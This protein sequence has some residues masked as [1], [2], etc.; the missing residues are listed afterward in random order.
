MSISCLICADSARKMQQ[1]RGAIAKYCTPELVLREL[2]LADGE[3]AVPEYQP[4]IIVMDTDTAFEAMLRQIGMLRRRNPEAY[5]VVFV[6]YRVFSFAHEAM[7]LERVEF[8]P[9]PMRAEAL[10]ESITRIVEQIRRKKAS[11]MSSG[12]LESVVNDN[13]P[14]IRQ[15]YLSLLMRSG[16]SDAETVKRKFATLQIDC[17]GPFYTVVIV[18]M[19]AERGKPDYEAV[20]FLVLSSLRSMLKTEGYQVYIFFDSE[21]RINCLIGHEKRLQKLSIREIMERLSNYCLLYMEARLYFGIGETVESAAQIHVSFARAESQMR[22]RSRDG[23]A[24]GSR[25]VEAAVRFMEENLSD[26]TLDLRTVSASL[27][28]SRSYFS[29][30]FRQAQGEGFSAY[31]QRR[32]IEQAKQLLHNSDYGVQEVARRCGFSSPKYFATVFK[33]LEGVGPA[34]YRRDS[35]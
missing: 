33:K 21:Y 25:S 19:P 14:V 32:R 5:F 16:V 4:H 18:D 34:R 15:H 8:L 11:I 31:L 7:S 3:E 27:G 13:I 10:Q 23:G 26:P 6:R 12:Q 30:V 35:H 20:S 17:P 24:F 2:F 28:F 9:Q 22:E 29:R 1:I